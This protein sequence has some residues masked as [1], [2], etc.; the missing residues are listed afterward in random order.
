MKRP[1]FNTAYTFDHEAQ[2]KAQ[3]AVQIDEGDIVMVTSGQSL[4][5]AQMLQR[6]KNGIPLPISPN[7]QWEDETDLEFTQID[8]LGADPLTNIE[9]LNHRKTQLEHDQRMREKAAREQS[10]PTDDEESKRA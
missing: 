8:E 9:N 2:H 7:Q 5:I 1:K 4:T 3:K 10:Q 6:Y